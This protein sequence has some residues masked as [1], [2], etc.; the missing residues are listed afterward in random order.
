MQLP[1]LSDGFR[2]CGI[3]F[4]RWFR[5]DE[6]LREVRHEVERAR[7]GMRRSR[8]ACV[9]NHRLHHNAADGPEAGDGVI[10]I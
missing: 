2:A 5:L 8:A 10:R 3:A 6:S 7:A 9:F 1:S 4:N